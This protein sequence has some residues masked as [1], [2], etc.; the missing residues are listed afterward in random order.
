MNAGA[1]V[2]REIQG[3]ITAVLGVLA[4]LV[5]V[6]IVSAASP[7]GAVPQ[8]DREV[9]G[10]IGRTYSHMGGPG[11][12][13]G[14][15]LTDELV[16]PDGVGRRMQFEH[17]TIYWSPRSGA[18]PVW[19]EI[20]VWWCDEGCEAGWPRYPT[21]YEYTVG[22]EIRQNFECAVVHFKALPGGATKTWSDGNTCV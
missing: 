21:S 3:R 20:G 4:L 7:A 2:R 13:L 15:S 19:G 5:S 8:C 6:V 11:G 14:C 10:E 12:A 16:N 17:G 1:V 22:D 18:F 9:G